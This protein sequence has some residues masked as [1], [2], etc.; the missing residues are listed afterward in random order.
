MSL[1]SNILAWRIPWTEKP[2]RLQFKGFP[3]GSDCKESDTTEGPTLSQGTITYF[4]AEIVPL[5]ELCQAHP[6]TSN[7][8]WIF[9]APDLESAIY[10]NT[11]APDVSILP[12]YLI[13]LYTEM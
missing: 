11:L 10:L 3:S 4:I 1:H 8:S 13:F 7:L 2:D 6:C 9:S 5:L 12:V